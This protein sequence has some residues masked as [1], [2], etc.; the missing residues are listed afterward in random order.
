M[1]RP[2]SPYA[3]QVAVR[4]LCHSR[5]MV[6]R[7]SDKCCMF[8]LLR[9]CLLLDCSIAYDFEPCEHCFKPRRS[10]SQC[11]IAGAKCAAHIC[12]DVSQDAI[13]LVSAQVQVRGDSDNVGVE[14]SAR[15]D[16]IL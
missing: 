12:Q 10:Y 15:F 8:L 13:P 4:W 5:E 14:K 3:F 9:C 1:E 16:A 6:P 7:N 2:I 11:K